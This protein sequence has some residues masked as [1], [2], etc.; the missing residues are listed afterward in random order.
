MLTPSGTVRRSLSTLLVDVDEPMLVDVVELPSLVEVDPLLVEVL[1]P[2]LVEVVAPMLVDVDGVSSTTLDGVDAP[3]EPD[4]DSVTVGAVD[5]AGPCTDESAELAVFAVADVDEPSSEA[6]QATPTT[7]N[8]ATT[9]VSTPTVFLITWHLLGE[10]WGN[11]A[12]P[13]VRRSSGDAQGVLK[14][15]RCHVVVSG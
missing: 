13:H 4:D 1:V 8:A 9:D 15:L 5:R 12:S 14:P 10:V 2:L 11:Y 6:A 7:A 3:I